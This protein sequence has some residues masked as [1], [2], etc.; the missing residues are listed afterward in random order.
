MWSEQ[1]LYI[2]QEKG[3]IGVNEVIQ[4]VLLQVPVSDEVISLPSYV[5][6]DLCVREYAQEFASVCFCTTRIIQETWLLA[7]SNLI[8]L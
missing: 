4:F 7:E 3:Y 1:M 8:I 6:E 5:T 2:A